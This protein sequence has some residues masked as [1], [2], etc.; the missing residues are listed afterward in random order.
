MELW[1]LC[2]DGGTKADTYHCIGVVLAREEMRRWLDGFAYGWGNGVLTPPTMECIPA[3]RYQ[4][5]L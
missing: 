1:S 2:S 4:W 3:F 5:L